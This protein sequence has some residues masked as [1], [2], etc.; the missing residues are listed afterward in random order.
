MS[1]E[2]KDGVL[3][4]GTGAVGG[5]FAAYMQRAGLPI[6]AVDIVQDHVAISRDRGLH[7]VTS[8][9]DFIVKLPICTPDEL[10]GQWRLA[11]LAVKAQNTREACLGVAKHLAPGGA[12]LAL[13]N[14]MPGEIMAEYFNRRNIFISV[15]GIGADYDG[16]GEIRSPIITA[17]PIGQV[18]GEDN[19]ILEEFL[20]CL[21]AVHP[22]SFITREIQDY[23]W[24]KHCSNALLST[25]AI[26]ASPMA[27]ILRRPDLEPVW[28]GVIGEA[29][30]V[31]QA[32]GH[33]PHAIFQLDPMGFAPGAPPEKGAAYIERMA[34]LNSGPGAKTHSGSWRDMAILKRKPESV[35]LIG[36]IVALGQKLGV[37]CPMLAHL[38]EI[39]E[40]IEE[41]RREQSDDNLLDL[42]RAGET[43]KSIS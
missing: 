21:K 43:A 25:S 24:A 13:Q 41:G 33:T 42:L 14:G 28:R 32:A 27:E 1:N 2:I 31:A 12:V 23:A 36:P 37:A 40:E 3:L 8:S 20:V 39:V 17:F 26:A 38:V 34:E 9:D 5:V 30:C 19:K 22:D 7:L 16:P 4:W 29:V 35:S 6:Q 15:V 10:E 11:I 18:D